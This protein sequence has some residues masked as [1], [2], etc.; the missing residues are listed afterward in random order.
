MI[1]KSIILRLEATSKEFMFNNALP[2]FR[3]FLRKYPGSHSLSLLESI[4][5]RM[6][7]KIN[8]SDARI[9]FVEIIGDYGE[10]IEDAI[11]M[12]AWS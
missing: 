1:I 8:E 3:S 2:V 4:F 9:A 12:V 10:Y 5:Y 6:V 11:E 7:E